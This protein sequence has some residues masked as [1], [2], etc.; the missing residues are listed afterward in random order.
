MTQ[1]AEV[2]FFDILEKQIVGI[3]DTVLDDG[4]RL[5]ERNIAIKEVLVD[6]SLGKGWSSAIELN[7][8]WDK[9]N[10]ADKESKRDRG[11]RGENRC[12]RKC[13]KLIYRGVIG[14]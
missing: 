5:A 14:K 8:A 6:E 11:K 9:H 10:L 7:A 12:W 1:L 2:I 4:G 3:K 13:I